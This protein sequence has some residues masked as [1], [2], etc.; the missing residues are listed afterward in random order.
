[1]HMIYN[2]YSSQYIS[3]IDSYFEDCPG[4][5][6]RFRDKCDFGLVR[7]CTFVH[8]K[9]G[10]GIKF[11]SMP[12]YND[13][14]PFKGNESFATNYSFTN[15]VFKS[16]EPFVIALNF[17]NSGYSAIDFNYLLTAEEGLI[18]T[19]GSA[20]EK[21]ILLEKNFGIYPQKIR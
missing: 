11:I 1:S 13:G 21:K 18:L 3:V 14:I 12:L 7:G 5:Y 8:P 17:L 20:E 10:P 6:I 15:N 4:D 19:K 16:G 2:A 9:N